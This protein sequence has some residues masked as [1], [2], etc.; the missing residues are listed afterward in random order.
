MYLLIFMLE[1]VIN[2]LLSVE[3]CP[4]WKEFNTCYNNKNGKS[5]YGTFNFKQ[6]IRTPLISFSLY[7][8]FNGKRK[9]R[10]T[11]G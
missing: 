10:Y 1:K 5:L 6:D 11:N 3:K 4:Y 7:R 8:T 2:F 9:I